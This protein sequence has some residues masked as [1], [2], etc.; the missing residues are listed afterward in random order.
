MEV[1]SVNL[2]R[3]ELDMENNPD[4][5]EGG[6][7]W[8]PEEELIVAVQSKVGVV[9]KVPKGV[10]DQVP[11]IYEEE[12]DVND[13]SYIEEPVRLQRAWVQEKVETRE[14]DKATQDSQELDIGNIQD[15]LEGDQTLS[16]EEELIAAEQSKVGVVRKVAMGTNDQAAWIHE[17]DKRDGE[18]SYSKNSVTMQGAR[19]DQGKVETREV[20]RANQ[21]RQEM[22][23][24]NIP[25]WKGEQTWPPGEELVAAEQ[26][27]VGVVRKV[28]KGTS[29]QW[30]HEEDRDD[31]D[32][33]D[34]EEESD[35]DMKEAVGDTY[36][37]Q[38]ESVKDIAGEN[39]NEVQQDNS[40]DMTES[41][42]LGIKFQCA[43]C[44]KM[45]SQ[46]KSFNKHK[47]LIPGTK[48]PCPSCN[49][50]ISYKF[51]PNHI[52]MHSVSKVKCSKCAR[53]FI[54]T[55]KLNKH[56][57][58]HKDVYQCSSCS[59]IFE[60]SRLLKKHT[61][62]DHSDTSETKKKELKCKFCHDVFEYPDHLFKHM[63]Q[64][65]LK[66]QQLNVR[67]ALKNTLEREVSENT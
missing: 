61:K 26:N 67:F 11:W 10:S 52:K 28:P 32:T 31:D 2:D 43:T 16:S 46:L 66:M 18:A 45:Y 24:Q 58:C 19:G 14:V 57:K 50:L 33:S 3:Q 22:D 29:D 8:P 53:I 56:M 47:C 12:E 48:K 54:S 60:N 42:N 40:K 21:D 6:L 5:M 59:A 49:K 41:T 9:R 23:L 62:L 38:N 17:E 36:G 25:D 13:A 7:I 39:G 20:D 64:T 30:I 55:E 15:C 51:L 63:E 4:C 37:K 35:E 27:K 65:I 44:L 34:S 1:D